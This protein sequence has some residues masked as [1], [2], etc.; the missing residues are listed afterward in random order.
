MII[1]FVFKLSTTCMFILG[2]ILFA[3][4]CFK[5]RDLFSWLF[6]F[7]AGSI[8]EFFRLI[9]Q[10][11]YDIYYITGLSFSTLTLLLIIVA[12][13]HEYYTTFLHPVKSG[14]LSIV[15]LSV[16]QL[17][18]SIGLQVIIGILLFIALFLIL[19]IYLKKKTPTHAFLCFILIGG[20]LNLIASP[21]RDAGVEGAEEFFLFSSAVMATNVLLTGIVAL[22]E[23]KLVNSE[24]KHRL[25]Y[26]RAE[27][28]KDL[29]VHDINNILQN[30]EFSLEI[31]SQQ[32]GKHE[33]KEDIKELL[34]LA[35]KQVN[36]GA[37]LG[38]NVRKLSDLELGKI[39]TSPMNLNE[40]IEK[41]IEFVQPRFPEKKVNISF[42]LKEKIL[43]V[44]ANEFL[45]D[46]FRIIIN[47]AIRYNDSPEVKIEI[48]ITPIQEEGIRYVRVEFMDNGT[49]MPDAMKKN[50]FFRIYDDPKSFKRFGLGLLLVREVIQSLN[51]KVWAE[52]RIKG[53][54][55]KGSNIIILI[56]ES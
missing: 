15:L 27:L 35:K 48:R 31:I 34:S 50:I 49:G 12:V 10:E 39:N 11:D 17:I 18:L 44:N 46:T 4:V 9:S 52:D 38:I 54:F 32:C 56:P 51:G 43:T 6:A 37:E 22:I 21:L 23:D 55:K 14:H 40:N 24:K 30:L 13:S 16:I 28:Y 45:Y 41:A 36:R 2:T 7:I 29:F 25:A 1:Y 20:I 47:N 8:S 53:D 26:N 33:I 42:D 3:G 5:R 19:R